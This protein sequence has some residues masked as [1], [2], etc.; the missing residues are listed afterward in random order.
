MTVVF[1]I[2]AKVR[3]DDFAQIPLVDLSLL[4]SDI[5]FLGVDAVFDNCSMLVLIVNEVN[6]FPIESWIALV[7]EL[8]MEPVIE[9]VIGPATGSGI[10]LVMKP[11][12]LILF[13]LTR[14][15]MT[16]VNGPVMTPET[17][18]VIGP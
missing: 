18:P 12:I 6:S 3:P 2:V 13:S 5:V 17:K 1:D 11:G 9:S 4:G 15:V 8:G 10:R 14:S 7:M 16:L